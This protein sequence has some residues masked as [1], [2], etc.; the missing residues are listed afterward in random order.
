MTTALD[1]THRPELRSWVESAN[2]LAT[3][4]PVQNLPLGIFRRA[5]GASCPG[6]AIGDQILD[7]SAAADAKL[8]SQ[9]PTR[10]VGACLNAGALNPV[11]E[12]GQEQMRALRAEVSALL[13]DDTATGRSA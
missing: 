8:L 3:D 6:V 7:L 2:A 12:A 11:I 13:R 5:D 1:E 10:L 9:N 4:F